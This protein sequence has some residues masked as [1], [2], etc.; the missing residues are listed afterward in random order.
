MVDAL[1]LAIVRVLG[2]RTHERHTIGRQV[3]EIRRGSRKEVVD[4]DDLVAGLDQ[5]FYEMRADESGAACDKDSH[6]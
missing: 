4:D 6:R 3:P 5:E 2:V 1:E